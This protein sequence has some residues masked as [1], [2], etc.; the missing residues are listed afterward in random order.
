MSKVQNYAKHNV[1]CEC[2]QKFSLHKEENSEVFETD[3]RMKIG[4]DFL[5]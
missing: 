1:I 3:S 2:S 4:I 5:A